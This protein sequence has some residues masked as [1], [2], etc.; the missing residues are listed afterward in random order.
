LGGGSTAV[1]LLDELVNTGEVLRDA[2]IWTMLND[3]FDP[4]GLP[5]RVSMLRLNLDPPIDV[6][7][8]RG[9]GV[10]ETGRRSM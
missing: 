1:A 2:Q 5:D 10:M 9:R 4:T 3:N 6:L 8:R 7:V